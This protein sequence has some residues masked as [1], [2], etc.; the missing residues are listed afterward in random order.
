MNTIN[1]LS[2]DKSK[3]HSVNYAYGVEA[4]EVEFGTFP[5]DYKAV[6]PD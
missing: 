1:F 4:L 2:L 3:R 5:Q 6:D